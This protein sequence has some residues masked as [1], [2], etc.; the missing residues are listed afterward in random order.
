[1]KKNTG[2][3]LRLSSSEKT[4]LLYILENGPATGY[5][6]MTKAHL[7][8]NT[9]YTAPKKL[10][11]KNILKIKPYI[12]KPRPGQPIKEYDLTLL[13]LCMGMVISSNIGSDLIDKVAKHWGMLL[14]PLLS[15]WN[16]FKSAELGEE[17]IKI[18]KLLCE[19]ILYQ[20]TGFDL[21]G[22]IA[23]QFWLF[24]FP[25]INKVKWLRA[26]RNNP[27]LRKWAIKGLK[28]RVYEDHV[29]T[30]M[31]ESSLTAIENTSEPDWDQVTHNLRWHAPQE[32]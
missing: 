9:G 6:L 4:A 8:T 25:G 5:T 10:I 27:E 14:P 18:L 26:F 11:K 19:V 12:G 17:F 31:H 15:N 13:G 16:Y 21:E 3:S 23:E 1:M 2:S 32:Y 28:E 29:F 22:W 30:K 7:N 24:I 20:G